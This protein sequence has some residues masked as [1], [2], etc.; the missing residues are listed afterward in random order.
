MTGS[1]NGSLRRY[2]TYLTIPALL[3]HPDHE[4]I[5]TPSCSGNKTTTTNG[6][7]AQQ[8]GLYYFK[9]KTNFYA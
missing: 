8:I 3:L 5:T 4:V 7:T 6:K 9:N 1:F 2:I